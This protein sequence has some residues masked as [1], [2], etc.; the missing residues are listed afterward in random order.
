MGRGNWRDAALP[1]ALAMLCPL[2][3]AQGQATKSEDKE[4]R[5]LRELRDDPD[6]A[7]ANQD[8]LLKPFLR[9]ET[10]RDPVKETIALEILGK[11]YHPKPKT[12]D[13]L[14]SFL[15]KNPDSKTSNPNKK[16]YEVLW[17]LG[18]MGTPS[19]SI[20]PMIGRLPI[21]QDGVGEAVQRISGIAPPSS[22]VLFAPEEAAE[23][24]NGWTG[25]M[26]RIDKETVRLARDPQ[27]WEDIWREHAWRS[28]VPAVDFSQHAVLAYFQG[29]DR[30]SSGFG[31]RS[32]EEFRSS[33]A[34]TFNIFHSEDCRSFSRYPFIMLLV[35][36]PE[37]PLVVK[38]ISTAETTRTKREKVLAL[39]EP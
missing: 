20:L 17:A 31:R 6:L 5:K 32:Y 16:H 36:R 7:E 15:N 11:L 39:F 27:D 4:L 2:S 21:I 34:F 33:A 13:T 37:V 19:K 29:T 3:F 26:S 23:Q 38:K 8:L 10:K 30:C 1:I 35:R 12:L 22:T 24:I 18:R 14:F 9:A 28:D 25:T